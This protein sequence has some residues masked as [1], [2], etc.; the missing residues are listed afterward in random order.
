MRKEC[1]DHVMAS[2]LHHRVPECLLTSWPR[3]ILAASDRPLAGASNIA[4][5][6]PC[7]IPSTVARRIPS[8][9]LDLS[10]GIACFVSGMYRDN[11]RG[12]APR[13]RQTVCISKQ[14]RRVIRATNISEVI[15]VAHPV[16]ENLSVPREIYAEGP[17]LRDLFCA[18]RAVGL[19]LARFRPAI[20]ASVRPPA[21]GIHA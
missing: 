14:R 16:A 8:A 3:A 5:G 9:R 17:S 6:M 11:R 15:S 7:V 21:R 20:A 12:L 4:S 18:T 13:L 1:A 19:H 2:G 10:S